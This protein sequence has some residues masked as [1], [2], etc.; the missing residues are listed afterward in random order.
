M[1]SRAIVVAVVAVVGLGSCTL[2]PDP[3]RPY[4]KV[5]T[6]ADVFFDL[7]QGGKRY[8]LGIPESRY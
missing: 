5:I 8:E 4:Q 1:M 2:G 3:S 6:G 7:L